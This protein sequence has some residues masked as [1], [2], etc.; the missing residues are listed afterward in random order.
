MKYVV[1]P[2]PHRLSKLTTNDLFMYQAIGLGLCLMYGFILFK[3][4]VLIVLACSFAACLATEFVCCSIKNKK[5]MLS[6]MSFIVTALMLTCIMPANA[7]WYYCLIAGF[8]AIFSKYIFGGLGNNIFNPAAL[9]RAVLGCCVAGLA[10]F[11][12]DGGKTPLTLLSEG[13]R[14]Q[15]IL[16]NLF[17]GK[18]A[19]AIGTTCMIIIMICAIVY[20]IFGIIRWENVLFALGGFAL[21]VGVAL[22]GGSI[23]PYALSGSFLF[24][25]VFM[26]SDPVT[27][28]YGQ[29]TRAVYGMLFGVLSALFL[30]KNIM[31]ETGVFL[32]LLI[33]NF[34]AP[35]LDR[36]MSLFHRGGN[37]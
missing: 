4:P 14:S 32:A 25:T 29:F 22:G 31:G 26:L 7:R 35:A 3:W 10:S 33:C 8:V 1:T 21:Y 17:I 12:I 20:L 23:L 6:D 16:N 28:P 5:F 36:V 13:S 27:S 18:T 24:V 37:K 9:G 30:T 11:T 19:G 34:I 15:I 2:A